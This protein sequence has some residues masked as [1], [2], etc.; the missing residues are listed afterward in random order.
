M[1]ILPRRILL[2]SLCAVLSIFAAKA[3]SPTPIIVQAASSASEVAAPSAVR[4]GPDSSSLS[5]A[6]RLLQ[7]I[8]AAN[9]E[10]LKK[11]QAVLEQLDEAQK[12]AEQIKIFAHRG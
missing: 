9:A 4:G 6:I 7:Q 1:N 2:L 5:D 11:Q 8:K 12:G 10:T 3:Q